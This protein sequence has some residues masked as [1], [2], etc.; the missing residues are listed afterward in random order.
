MILTPHRRRCR[1]IVKRTA[2]VAVGRNAKCGSHGEVMF[3]WHGTISNRE[4]NI[5]LGGQPRRF[6]HRNE[7]AVALLPKW[8]LDSSTRV[9]CSSEQLM[10]MHAAVLRSDIGLFF[11]VLVTETELQH[12]MSQQ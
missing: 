9:I 10:Y 1:L 2:F 11:P 3:T 7:R 12:E 5:E 4:R 8:A 6:R